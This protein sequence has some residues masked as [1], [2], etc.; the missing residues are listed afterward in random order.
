MSI[1]RI[2]VAASLFAWVLP[3]CAAAPAAPP[4]PPPKQA[5]S[6]APRPAPGAPALPAKRSRIYEDARACLAAGDNLA[7]MVCAEKYR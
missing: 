7:V 3:I 4:T 5:A 6:A 1:M 2:A